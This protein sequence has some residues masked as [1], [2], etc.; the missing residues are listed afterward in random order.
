MSQPVYLAVADDA[1]RDSL[2][3]ALGPTASPVGA[4]GGDL[5]L[6]ALDPG[7]LIVAPDVTVDAL[8]RLAAGLPPDGGGWTVA[9]ATPGPN[10][11]TFRAVSVG[12]DHTADEVRSR[13]A[14]PESS[15]GI[16]LDLAG[17]LV[18]IARARHDVNN[19][20]T[21]ALAETQLALLDAPEGDVREG[22]EVIQTQLRRIRDLVAATG[23][24]RPPRD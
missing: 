8:V 14:D 17:T 5:D 16:L 2:L 20:L 10:G 23:H 24:L 18:E 15:R 9:M 4:P 19:P 7:L 13:A 6:A 3:A 21:S 11:P 1:L 12:R 22:L